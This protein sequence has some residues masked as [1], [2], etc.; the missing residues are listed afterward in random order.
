MVLAVS[1]PHKHR[2]SSVYY[3][4]RVVPADLREAVGKREVMISLRTKDPAEARRKH[5]EVAAMVEREWQALRSP[6]RSLTQREIVALAGLIYAEEVEALSEEPG[7]ADVWAHVIEL[8]AKAREAGKLEQW[9]GPS[10]DAILRREGLNIDATSR[11]RL[12]E[13]VD[14][15]SIQASEQLRK[16]AEGDY[17]PDPRAS[18]FPEWK[19][20]DEPSPV[21]GYKTSK[22]QD[23]ATTITGL[24]A[25]WWR[26]AQLTGR[27][28]STYQ[29]YSAT[30]SKFVAFLGHDDATRVTPDDVVRFKDHRLAEIN[31]RSGKPVS[32]KTVKDSDLAGLKSVFGWAVT[33]RLLP[34]NPAEGVTIKGVGKLVRTRS[35]G[36]T[37]TEAVAVLRAAL[38]LK[39]GREDRKTY[40]AKRWVPWL[41][42]YTGARVGEFAQLRKGDVRQENGTWIVTITPEAGTVK[43]KQVREVPLH[44]HLVELGFPEFISSAP[45]GHLFVNPSP[46]GDVL[47]PLRGV[48]NRLREFVREIVPDER[49]QPFHAWRHRF[50]TVARELGIDPM[51]IDAIQGHASRSVSDEYGDATIKAMRRAVEAF[52]RFEVLL[53]TDNATRCSN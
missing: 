20:P 36:Y 14:A 42:A 41:C 6:A 46:T 4:R 8:H 49:V 11:A 35:K 18:R 23:K 43:T 30:I 12:I 9:L 24:L 10:V 29:S 15:A 3:F 22:P 45:D 34:A 33:N 32:P 28:A 31:P 7:S 19:R 2:K 21:K 17:S 5:A 38:N 37:D 47:G 39:P 13:A 48:V 16:N 51:I 1:S 50:K 40:A 52:P 53:S 44:P 25:G 27:S 26:E